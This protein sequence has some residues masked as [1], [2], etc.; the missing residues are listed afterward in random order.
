M[1]KV[2]SFI[3]GAV[4]AISAVSVQTIHASEIDRIKVDI[5]IKEV[6]E[7]PVEEVFEMVIETIAETEPMETITETIEETV[8]ETEE[9]EME[10]EK[11]YFDIP[12]SH[13][14]QDHIFEVCDR[15]NISPAFVIAVIEHESSFRTSI[16]GDDGK[17]FG[18]MQIQQKWHQGRM[19]RLGCTDLRNPYECVTVGVDFLAE[20]FHINPD[21]YWV[22]MAYNGGMSYANK[23]WPKGNISNYAKEITARVQYFQEMIE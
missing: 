12:L 23:H 18:L 21:V 5:P 13:D 11:I 6:L 10:I 8:E 20:L 4:M 19:E 15:Y 2:I 22:L 17:S 3:I 16:A 9:T 7:M 1:K 14:L